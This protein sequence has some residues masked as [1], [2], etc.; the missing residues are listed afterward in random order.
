MEEVMS[1]KDSLRFCKTQN[2]F[3]KELF[4]RKHFTLATPLFGATWWLMDR[5]SSKKYFLV[6]NHNQ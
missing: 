3:A 1:L 6:A 2:Y 4:E 5:E